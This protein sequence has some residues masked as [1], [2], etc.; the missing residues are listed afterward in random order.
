MLQTAE[1][2]A[3]RYNIPRQRMDEY[4]A[5]S[6][7]KATRG[8]GRGRFDAEMIS[9]DDARRRRR[10]AARACARRKSPSLPTKG[11]R[12]GTTYDGI[13]DIKPAIPG[14]VISAGN[15]SQFSDGA[16]AV[17]GDE[18]EARRAARPEAARPLPRL[19]GRP[20][21][22]PTRWASARCSPCRRS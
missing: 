8:E 17:R 2:V 18:R 20:A 9:G 3:K 4:G 14:G 10:C 21:A 22:S 15:A 13:K 7:Q 19:R 5:A 6:Q 12:P 1:Q 11:I 16:G